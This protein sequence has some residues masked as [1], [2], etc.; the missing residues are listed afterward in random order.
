MPVVHARDSA[1][2]SFHIVTIALKLGRDRCVA[3]MCSVGEVFLSSSFVLS[4]D[5]ISTRCIDVFTVTH[6]TD[7]SMRQDYSENALLTSE[8]ASDRRLQVPRH[9]RSD[10]S[11]TWISRQLTGDFA[12]PPNVLQFL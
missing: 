9:T 2:V 7:F 1:I 6:T 3:A 4:K 12:P 8:V 11:V 5:T 10:E